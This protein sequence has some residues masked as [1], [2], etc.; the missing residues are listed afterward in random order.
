MEQAKRMRVAARALVAAMVVMLTVTGCGLEMEQ[1]NEKITLAAQHQQEAE[2]VLA[3][4]KNFT[5]E[6]EAVFN[7]PR[8]G[9]DQVTRARQLVQA[10]V[11][12][13]DALEAALE[14][15]E[16][17]FRAIS[18]L[19]VEEKIKEYV[20][21]KRNAIKCYSGYVTGSLRPIFKAY[22][23]LVELIAQGQPQT[24]LD[25]TAMEIAGLVTESREKLEECR[26]AEKQA[27]E[28]F[29]ENRL[30]K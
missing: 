1:A 23:G 13:L 12:D 25:E 4:F 18:S 28:Y 10:R 27:D 3:R 8:V 19:N 14:K 20:R 29:E 24:V 11:Q 22:E 26:I 7:V 21:L 2:A 16:Q 5:A 6:W 9:P 17:D 30:G 15:W